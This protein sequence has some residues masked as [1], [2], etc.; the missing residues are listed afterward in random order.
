MNNSTDDSLRSIGWLNQWSE[1]PLAI[2][3]MEMRL[4]DVFSEHLQ[5][6]WVRSEPTSTERDEARKMSAEK[7]GHPDWNMRR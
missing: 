5:I 2:P 7:F 4:A 6:E 3:D 1:T